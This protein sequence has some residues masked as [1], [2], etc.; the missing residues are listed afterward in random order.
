MYI[1]KWKKPTEKATYY[2][3]LVMWHSWKSKTTV[4]SK[5]DKR[6]SKVKEGKWGG[7]G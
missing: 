2:M 7:D 4:D 5:K 3:I 1:A 6:L